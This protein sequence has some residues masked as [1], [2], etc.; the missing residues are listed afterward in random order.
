MKK[1]LLFTAGSAIQK[2]GD[3]IREEQEVLMHISNIVMEIFA[4]DTAIHRLMKKSSTD[5]HADVT[6]TFI[7]DAV[8]RVEFSAKQ[9][10]AAVADGDTLRTQIAALRRVLRWTPVNTVKARQRVADFLVESGRYA[11]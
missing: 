6:R 10:L 11:L 9:I 2:F 4:M 7:N 8:G 1:A 3:T 5:L